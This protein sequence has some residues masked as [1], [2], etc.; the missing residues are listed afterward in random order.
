MSGAASLCLWTVTEKDR[1]PE[2]YIRG[3]R[4]DLSEFMVLSEM[5]NGD[6][7]LWTEISG[8]K[9]RGLSETGP[10]DRRG[11]RG[12]RTEISLMVSH[13]RRRLPRNQGTRIGCARCLPC[14]C[15]GSDHGT[16]A[17]HSG[18]CGACAGAQPL[19][20]GGGGRAGGRGQ[21]GT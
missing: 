1:R 13:G 9:G 16:E 5:G 14:P 15:A 18:G 2:A 3:S 17:G 4:I 21:P 10:T 8:R 20:V 19:T 11:S 6:D 7:H 12:P